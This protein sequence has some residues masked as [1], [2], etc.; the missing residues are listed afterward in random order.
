MFMV[1]DESDINGEQLL[2]IL[3]GKL[4]AP[5]KTLLFN[6]KTLLQ[7]V[8]SNIVTRE[9]DDAVHSLGVAPENFCLLLTDAARYMTAAGTLFK[10]LNPR[11]F[12]VTCMA[13]LLH[14]CAM[15]VR[16]NYPAVDE[17]VARVKAVTI[18]N[19]SRRAFFTS[20]G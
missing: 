2:N 15:K 5:E 19:R 11:L 12:Q 1:V 8:D 16:A 3:V 18:K 10:K 4:T 7:S 14:S 20:I 6:C 13:H 17:L 9:I